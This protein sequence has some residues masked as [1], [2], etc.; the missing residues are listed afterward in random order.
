MRPAADARQVIAVEGKRLGWS[1]TARRRQ[2][3]DVADLVTLHIAAVRKAAAFAFY[4]RL[5]RLRHVSHVPLLFLLVI[6]AIVHI[7]AA[8]FF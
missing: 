1:R 2:V 4:K 7:F 6:A 8:Q 3:A 5:F